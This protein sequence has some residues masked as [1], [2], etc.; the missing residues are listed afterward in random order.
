VNPAGD[1][2]CEDG[3]PCTVDEACDLATGACGGGVPNTCDDGNQCTL[4]VCD[5][6]VGCYSLASQSPCCIGATSICDDNDVCTTD[7][8]DPD[9]TGCSYEFNTAPCDDGTIC[10]Q[11]DACD[12]GTCAGAAI[13]C[14]DGNPC[15]DDSCSPSVGCLHPPTADGTTCDDGLDCSVN[16]ACAAGQCGGDMTGCVCT[17]V[18]QD[19]VK[20]NSVLIG[21]DGTPGEGLDLDNNPATCAPSTTGCSDGIDNNL[22]I[23]AGFANDALAGA[24]ADGS[25]MLILDLRDRLTGPFTLGLFTGGLDPANAGCDHMT[26]TCDYQVSPSLVN[27]DTCEPT[28]SLPAT[29]TGDHLSAG[30]VGST[31]PFSIPFGAGA[32]LEIT[33]YD[34][35]FEATVTLSGDNVVT[36][37]GILGGAVPKQ[38]LLDAVDLL[39]ADALPAGIS[40][41]LIVTF[42][43]LV[44]NDYDTDGN[45]SLDAATIGIKVQGID[46]VVTGVTP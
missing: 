8:C 46:G 44:D 35:R 21:E 12:A 33:L 36:L 30:G 13:D 24:V 2:P 5:P 38:Q 42:L 10:T 22:G 14:D 39:P 37:N 15:T 7:V 20:L 9:T 41:D 45:G 32:T 27:A 43:G 19:G 17:P 3:D 34:A 18:F 28:I 1:G 29:L 23:L 40:K 6:D 31:F 4:D 11:A 16:D 25:F 26:A